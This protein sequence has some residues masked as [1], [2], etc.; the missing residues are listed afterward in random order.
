MPTDSM[1]MPSEVR[2]V[3]SQKTVKTTAT[4]KS[5]NGRI[6]PAV[7]QE[8]VRL[9][10]DLDAHALRDELRDAPARDHEDQ[11]RDHRLDPAV[12]DEDAVP[13]AAQR[14]HDE[15][16]DEDEPERRGRERSGRGSGP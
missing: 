16:H 8:G 14:R 15:G 13:E 10:E 2:R 5:E 3:S 7:A 4:M 1:N 12:G 11:R 6:D 9:V